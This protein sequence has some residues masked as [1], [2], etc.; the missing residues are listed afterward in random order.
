MASRHKAR[1]WA[2]QILYRLDLN[3]AGLTV[4]FDDFRHDVSVSEPA[5]AFTMELVQGI[6]E[7]LTELDRRIE[8]S[9]ENWRLARM[10]ATDRN[11]LRLGAY[12]LLYRPDIP[13]AVAIDQA[14]DLAKR[15][16]SEESG[17]FV[18]GILDRIHHHR[19]E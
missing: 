11:I 2:L 14:I 10:G 18:N 8:A 9:A 3:P 12:E 1:L 7:R 16:G 6:Q 19:E 15:F 4:A 13:P 17:K 5:F